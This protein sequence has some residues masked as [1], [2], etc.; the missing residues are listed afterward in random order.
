MKSSLLL[1][2][3]FKILHFVHRQNVNDVTI[4]CACVSV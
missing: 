4:Q 2:E 1:E 3:V